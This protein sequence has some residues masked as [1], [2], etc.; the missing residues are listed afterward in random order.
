[1]SQ[2]FELDARIIAAIRQDRSPL[3]CRHVSQ[4]ANRIATATGRDSFRVIDGRLQAMRKSGRIR[5][6]NGRWQFGAGEKA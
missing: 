5:Y 3:Y 2:Y 6:S 1:M 4:E